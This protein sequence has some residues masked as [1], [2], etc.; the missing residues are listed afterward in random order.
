MDKT[1]NIVVDGSTSTVYA[2]AKTF[3]TG[4]IGF[5]VFGKVFVNNEKYQLIGNLVKV[6]SKPKP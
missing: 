2:R 3:K 5:Y 6:H 4:S 1:I